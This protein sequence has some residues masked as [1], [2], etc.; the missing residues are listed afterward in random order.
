MTRVRFNRKFSSGEHFD[1]CTRD[2]TIHLDRDSEQVTLADS[3]L[4]ADETGRA[5][6]RKG[7]ELSR[8]VW[9]RKEFVLEDTAFRS[10]QLVCYLYEHQGNSSSLYI[11]VNGRP[12]TLPANSGYQGWNIWYP[13]PVP[14]ECFRTGRNEIVFH[15]DGVCFDSWR[16]GVE[17]GNLSNQSAKSIDSGR[18]WSYNLMGYD[19]SQKGEYLARLRLG[20]FASTGII[21]S[22]VI[23]LNPDGEVIK[24][25][26]MGGKVRVKAEVITPEGTEV[27]LRARLGRTLLPSP[28]DWT[29]WQGVTEGVWLEVT[30]QR[31]LQWEATLTTSD[32][33]ATPILK[34]VTVEGSLE[35]G[36][37]FSGLSVEEFNSSEIVESSFAFTYQ[38]FREPKLTI[39]RQRERLDAVVA[40]AQSEWDKFLLLRAWVSQQWRDAGGELYYCPW[41]ALV[42]LDW[43][44]R[45]NDEARAACIH[46]AV[47][48]CQCCL[49][50]GMQAR[51]LVLARRQTVHYRGHFVAEIWSN[52]HG[53]WIVMDPHLD[54]HYERDG[55]PLS[56]LELH[57]IWMQGEADSVVQVAGPG[58]VDHPMGSTWALDGFRDGL[59]RYWGLVLRN[60]HLTS[61]EPGPVEHGAV[62]YRW[63]GFLWWGESVPEELPQFPLHS[64]RVADFYWPLGQVAIDLQLKEE[65]TLVVHLT[66]CLPNLDCFEVQ[67][68]SGPWRKS[69]ALFPWRLHRGQN[70]LRA[71]ARSAFD[72]CGQESCAGLI[73]EGVEGANAQGG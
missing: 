34:A 29:A 21:T 72:V 53:K 35:L 55:V 1:H 22:P 62:T 51:L 36:E 54:I 3:V 18:T 58:N 46:F 6:H 16:L 56:A 31:F 73:W 20:R 61:L 4:L 9:A 44:R 25:P 39:L 38:D 66:T 24:R 50:L 30:G 65:D 43:K 48:F 28:E 57:Q 19:D 13:I 42:I 15:S 10:A 14:P 23:E 45:L 12:L 68:D 59:Y 26:V 40:G 17:N 7:E 49:A 64:S 63:T 71:R 60:N 27:A 52:E 69:A 8:F 47:V 41:D 2:V 5:L 33:L 37:R 32:P 67:I 70:S 11:E